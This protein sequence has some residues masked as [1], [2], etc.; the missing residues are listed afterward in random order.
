MAIEYV[1][2]GLNLDTAAAAVCLV[3]KSRLAAALVTGL[4]YR[5]GTLLSWLVL[6]YFAVFVIL[7]LRRPRPGLPIE[8]HEQTVLVTGGAHG[9]GL[10]LVERLILVRA[11]RIAVIDIQPEPLKFKIPD[12]NVIFYHCDL[13]DAAALTQTLKKIEED[14]GPLTVLVNN[15][16][17]LCPKVVAE[18]TMEEMDRVINVNFRAPAQLT[19]LVLPQ[20]LQQTGKC[21]LVFVASTLAFGGVPQLSTYTATKAALTMFCD[22]LKLELR[23]RH[24]AHHRVLV[25]TLYPSLISS[26][27]F[28][29]LQMPGW[30]S[31][32]LSVEYVSLLIFDL[33]QNQRASDLFMPLYTNLTPLYMLLP[34]PLKQILYWVTG[35]NQ[36]MLSYIGYS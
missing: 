28:E 17:T 33:I 34:D 31:P 2:V 12:N 25:S 29:G 23:H 19:R 22:S 36:A 5:A 8:W 6:S 32:V 26:G 27:M 9:V 1:P 11:P 15:A 18:Q 16:G 4:A 14:M 24:N 35:S 7:K 3:F 30:L 21:H 13:N 10:S 20:M